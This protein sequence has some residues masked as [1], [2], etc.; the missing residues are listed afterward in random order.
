MVHPWVNQVRTASKGYAQKVAA[1]P[2]KTREERIK[3]FL[4][5]AKNRK[6]PGKLPESV[7]TQSTA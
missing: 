4:E 2:T 7:A 6:V 3:A 1:A 5:K